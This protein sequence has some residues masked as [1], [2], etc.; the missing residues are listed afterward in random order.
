[1]GVSC[2]DCCNL[3]F[4]GVQH[5]TDYTAYLHRQFVDRKKKCF[6]IRTDGFLG[7]KVTN[8]KLYVEDFP[9]KVRL[10]YAVIRFVSII[11]KF[12]ICAALWA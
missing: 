11:A 3:P 8:N 1:M 12:C 5:R 9:C 2:V 4:T 6:V 10:D 7:V